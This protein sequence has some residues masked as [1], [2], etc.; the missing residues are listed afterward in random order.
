GQGLA[1]VPGM[2]AQ[3][4]A[5]GARVEKLA[6]RVL[7]DAEAAGRVLGVDH[8]E[9]ELQ[10]APE[11]R[12]VVADPVAPGLAD[13]V[14]EEGESHSENPCTGSIQS[15]HLYVNGIYMADTR[16]RSERRAGGCRAPLQA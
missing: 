9:V 15:S 5:V 7:S 2:I 12:Q 4:Q 3:R 10:L 1:L 11:A 8:H 6:G 14:S 16:S 13:H